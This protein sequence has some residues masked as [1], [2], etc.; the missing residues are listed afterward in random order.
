MNITSQYGYND[1]YIDLINKNNQR[2]IDINNIYKEVAVSLPE[3]VLNLLFIGITLLI[4]YYYILPIWDRYLVEYT[5]YVDL[6]L[7]GGVIFIIFAVL[8]L[9]FYTYTK[10]KFYKV[11]FTFIV[12]FVALYW[13]SKWLMKHKKQ[14]TIS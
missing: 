11:T 2:I 1:G 6:V 5:E 14:S 4:I 7:R 12:V 9:M 10:E 3:G 13:V 8:Y